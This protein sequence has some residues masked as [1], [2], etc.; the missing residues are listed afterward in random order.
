MADC[1]ETIVGMEVY[2]G[3]FGKYVDKKLCEE[4]VNIYDVCRRQIYRL[5]DASGKFLK[6]TR[7]L[8]LKV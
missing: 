4:L 1:N 6:E 5:W 8:G 3:I 7:A 2:K